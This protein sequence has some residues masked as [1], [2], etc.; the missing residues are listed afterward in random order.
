LDTHQIG[1]PF[2]IVNNKNECSFINGSQSII[3]FFQV[4]LT[5]IA[6]SEDENVECNTETCA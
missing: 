4:K 3:D 1:V 6:V 5:M 2:L